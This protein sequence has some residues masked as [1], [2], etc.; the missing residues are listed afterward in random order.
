MPRRARDASGYV[1]TAVRGREGPK[2]EHVRRNTVLPRSSVVVWDWGMLLN[3]EVI[4]LED[5]RCLGIPADI[6][7]SRSKAKPFGSA[8]WR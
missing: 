6:S 5:V 1:A 3:G 7:G 8:A 4:P 2:T